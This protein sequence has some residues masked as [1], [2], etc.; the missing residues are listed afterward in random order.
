MYR[1][2]FSGSVE[3]GRTASFLSAMAESSQH[4]A[5]RGIRARTNVWGAMTGRTN[6]VMIVS[7]F[8]TLDDLE[9]FTELAAE[10]A[11]FATIRRA[12]RAEMVY[13]DSDVSLQRLA[14][15]SEGLY[16]SE[17]ATKP[18][19]YMRTL[20]GEVLPGRHREFVMSV[21]QALAYQKERGID[22][23]T[24]V[25]TNVTGATSAV[26][27][28]AEFSSLAELEKFDELAQGDQDFA[29]LRKAT[30][31]AMVFHTSEVHI[32]RNLL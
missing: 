9:K 16:S 32:Y 15:H 28:V 17:E 13:E 23:V 19:K 11:T 3:R 14:Y 10:D 21:S 4:Q 18:Q 5:E 7:D 8:N 29:R 30:R 6:E 25:W 27:T 12:V 20:R 24:S 22:A 26:A 31:E 2:L 1:R